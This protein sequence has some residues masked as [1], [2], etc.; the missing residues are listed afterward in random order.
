MDTAFAGSIEG[1]RG[2]DKNK[3]CFLASNAASI[4]REK[5]EPFLIG[6]A[7]VTREGD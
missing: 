6:A 5:S 7:R 3:I 4:I 1:V 2:W